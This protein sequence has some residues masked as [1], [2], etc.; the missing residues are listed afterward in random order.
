MYE[1]EEYVQQELRKIT[2]RQTDKLVI[3]YSE[4]DLKKPQYKL[5]KA[6]YLHKEVILEKLSPL[7]REDKI[8]HLLSKIFLENFYTQETPLK[9]LT[10][11]KKEINLFLNETVNSFI[12]NKGKGLYVS[13]IGYLLNYKG[14]EVRIPNSSLSSIP[15]AV[16]FTLVTMGVPVEN[17]VPLAAFE[18]E[19]RETLQKET[20]QKRNKSKIRELYDP[21]FIPQGKLSVKDYF[22]FLKDFA[23]LAVKEESR[24]ENNELKEFSRA[25]LRDFGYRVFEEKEFPWEEVFFEYYIE[26]L[27]YDKKFLSLELADLS[28]FLGQLFSSKEIKRAVEKNWDRYSKAK[29]QFI[30]IMYLAS[31]G[32]KQKDFLLEAHRIFREA[33]IYQPKL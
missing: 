28:S 6:L 3:D 27:G 1:V 29:K 25:L 24:N 19:F 26:S 7:S 11:F 10:E 31:R 32:E 23:V 9:I 13:E 33:E 12:K 18:D 30:S 15:N 4:C 22:K 5:P 14:K 21:H 2:S 17:V 20:L 8:T 16:T